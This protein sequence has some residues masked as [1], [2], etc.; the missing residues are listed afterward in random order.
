VPSLA[1]EKTNGAMAAVPESHHEGATDGAATAG[2]PRDVT[3]PAAEEAPPPL[4]EAG[5][6]SFLAD[7]HSR[8]EVVSAPPPMAEVE[9]TESAPL[10][11]LDSL[12]Q[13]LPAEVREALDDL[14]RAKFVRV[15]RVPKR[16]LKT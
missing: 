3:A 4:D 10:P 1:P 2:V 15:Q 12:V 16:A 11:P 9:E 13:R 7:A 6:A 5:E 14:F 8:G